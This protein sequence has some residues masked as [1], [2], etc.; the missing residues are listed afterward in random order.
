MI[1]K[2]MRLW[3]VLLIL[4]VLAILLIWQFGYWG[5][6]GRGASHGINDTLAQGKTTGSVVTNTNTC[7]Q[8]PIQTGEGDFTPMDTALKCIVT[9]Y[10]NAIGRKDKEKVLALDTEL[11]ELVYQ[12]Q[13]I[14]NHE[15]WKVFW[16]DKEPSVFQYTNYWGQ[17]RNSFCGVKH[18]AKIV[19][20]EGGV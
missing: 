17:H 15:A 7:I 16:K 11:R 20:V 4:V 14:R 18:R 6:L 3:V 8:L 13:S 2:R 12:V 19:L 9:E 5:K 1:K 10:T